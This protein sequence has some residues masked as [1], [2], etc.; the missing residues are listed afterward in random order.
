MS[1]LLTH[2]GVWKDYNIIGVPASEVPD[3]YGFDG[4]AGAIMVSE[5]ASIAMISKAINVLT[6]HEMALVA[7]V[8]LENL[9][10]ALA[11]GDVRL[12]DEV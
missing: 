11:N 2:R 6:K 1:I 3:G 12:A 9:V 7:G 10:P 4:E 8:S 5:D